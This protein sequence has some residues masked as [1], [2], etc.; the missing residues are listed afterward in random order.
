MA[1]THNPK[2]IEYQQDI[3]EWINILSYYMSKNTN[4]ALADVAILIATILSDEDIADFA[5]TA[6]NKINDPSTCQSFYW[7]NDAK[8]HTL[9]SIE[10]DIR[11]AKQSINNRVIERNIT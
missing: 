11:R 9:S 8:N 4:V 7:G 10:Q 5:K 2:Y 1:Y 6:T 3:A